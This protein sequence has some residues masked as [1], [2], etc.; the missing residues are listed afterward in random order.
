MLFDEDWESDDTLKLKSFLLTKLVLRH[1][2]LLGLICEVK[3]S[4]SEFVVCSN[5]RQQEGGSYSRRGDSM[6]YEMTHHDTSGNKYT[7]LFFNFL[8][9]TLNSLLILA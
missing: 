5:V 3:A 2:R 1:P 4:T 7:Y 6:D 8:S 9:L